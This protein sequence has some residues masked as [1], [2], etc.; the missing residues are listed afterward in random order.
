MQPKTSLANFEALTR[1]AGLPLT[2]AQ[3]DELYAGWAYV[4]PMLARIRTEGRG[5]DAEPAL[6]FRPEPA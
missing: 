5:R 4:E 1:R 3:I 2:P 6:V